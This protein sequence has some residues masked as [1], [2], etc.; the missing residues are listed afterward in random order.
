MKKY[1]ELVNIQVFTSVI[2][3]AYDFLS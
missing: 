1:N 2:E 3:Y